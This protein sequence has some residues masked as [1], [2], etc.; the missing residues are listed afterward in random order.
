VTSHLYRN[1]LESRI[2]DA[3]ILLVLALAA[4]LTL[5]PLIYTVVISFSAA[6]VDNPFFYFWPVSPHFGNYLGL[7]RTPIFWQAYLNTV[8]YTTAGSLL[9]VALTVIT[10]YPMS[11][12]SFPFRN[13]FMFFITFTMLFSGGLIPYYLLIRSLG[14]VNTPWVMI[15]PGALSAFNVIL[16]R[17][18]FKTTIPSELREAAKIDGAG[19]WTILLRIVFPLSTP[20][21]AVIALFTAVGIWNSY[22]SALIFLNDR[23]LYPVA[24]ILREIVAGVSGAETLPAEMRTTA[25]IAGVRAATLVV[26]ILPIMCVY[27]FLQ[28]YFVKGIMIGAIKG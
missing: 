4:I 11:I 18:Y 22:F 14:L 7:V 5:Y 6:N 26:S 12:D 23:N 20:I 16:A 9:A 15:V 13:F 27:P 8:F 10:A 21:V 1:S 2:F 3:L 24:L 19:E 28:K 17:T 25:S